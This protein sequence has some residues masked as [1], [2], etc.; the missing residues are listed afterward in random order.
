[1]KIL[2]LNAW[3]GVIYEPL[4]NFI[5][6]QQA[7]DIFCFQEILFGKEAEFTTQFKARKNLCTELQAILSEYDVYM[8][9]H[10]DADFFEN[11][12]LIGTPYG[13]AIFYKKNITCLEQ[14]FFACCEGYQNSSGGKVTGRCQWIKFNYNGSDL[15]LLN[16]HGLSQ[17]DT[18]KKDTEE[19]IIQSK[20]LLKFIDQKNT[21]L[22]GDYNLAPETK[23]MQMLEQGLRNLISTYNITNTRSSL[24]KKE[25]RFADYCLL[26]N[27]VKE[28]S[29]SVLN[30]EVSD[31]LP[32]LLEI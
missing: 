29:F 32:L 1:M 5:K 31:H 4:I 22:I 23:S 13:Q 15:Y 9:W 14:G 17:I 8:S 28:K 6:E 3:G 12:P 26:S 2:S 16:L 19:R 21:V 27:Q 18:F 11:E 24:Y 30:V 20:T 7:V 10:Q 25:P